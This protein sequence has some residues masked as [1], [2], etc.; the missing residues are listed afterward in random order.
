MAGTFKEF[1]AR[2]FKAIKDGDAAFLKTVYLDWFESSAVMPDRGFGDF[3]AAAL[4]DL[5]RLP[6]LRLAR[7]E[8][9]DDYC[10]AHLLNKDG[11]ETT[12]T[13]KKK[14]DSY[15]FFNERSGFASFKKVYALNYSLDGGKLRILFNG[16]RSPVVHEI[17]SFGFVTFINSAL[18]PGAN[19]ITLEPADAGAS[20]KASIRV[21][22]GTEG[23][24]MESAQGNVL[25]WDGTVSGPVMLKFNAE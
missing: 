24:I 23:E 6:E 11:S 25:S 7:E 19:E 16:K 13:F 1:I 17:G 10:I 8:V 18:K 14:G 2:L 9:F 12:L 21:S 22:S 15:V 20:V 5:R 3:I 4:P